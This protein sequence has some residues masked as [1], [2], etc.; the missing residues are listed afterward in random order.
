MTAEDP[1]VTAM[2]AHIVSQMQSNVEFLVSQHHISRAD[3]NQI[4]A[5]LPSVDAGDAVAQPP[6]S[7]GNAATRTPARATFPSPASTP[8]APGGRRQVPAAPQAVQARAIWSYN[9]NNADPS[10]LSFSAGDVIE[11]VEESNKDWW[12][13]KV[14]GKQ[15][16]FPA[17]YVEKIPST[18]PAVSAPVKEKVPYRPFGAAFHGMD[19]PPPP[20]QGVNSVGLQE[21]DNSE[22]QSRNGQLKN[23][24]A[25]SAA[26]GVGFGAGAAI[27][28]GLVRAIF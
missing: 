2:L 16:L 3:A 9:E 20:G 5:K 28:G 6:R 24:L 17:N 15:A 1:Q 18:A 23:T 13:G 7:F 8:P 21:K 25:H 19:K 26:G 14:N 4:L 27:G 11:I 12:M 10:D 22:K